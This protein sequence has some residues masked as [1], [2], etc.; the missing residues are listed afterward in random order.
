MMM[1]EK[2]EECPRCGSAKHWIYDGQICEM[3]EPPAEGR[4][5]INA[6]IAAFSEYGIDFRAPWEC[7]LDD[8]EHDRFVALCSAL[9]AA[10]ASLVA[11]RERAEKERDR[12]REELRYA[13]AALIGAASAYRA[14]A[15]RSGHIR[16]RSRPDPF[17]L[18]R[19]SD[20]DKAA[21]QARAALAKKDPSNG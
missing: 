15:G 1:I 14:H 8:L 16:P 18:T 4:A 5:R 17:F 13:C 10:T 7:D 12:F 9:A 3:C 6:A 21:E 20:M 11:E 19:V 2:L